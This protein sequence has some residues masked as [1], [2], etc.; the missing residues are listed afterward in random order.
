[1][2]LQGKIAIVTGAAQ[3]IGKAIAKKLAEE[4]AKVYILDYN[5]DVAQKTVETFQANG[6]QS[7]AIKCDI[8]DTS[9]TRAIAEDI[10]GN[11]RH[12]DILVNNAGISQNID[13]LDMDEKNWDRVFNINLRGPFFLTQIIFKNMIEHRNGRIVNLASLAGERGGR[14]AAVNYSCSKGG[15]L[16]L[17]KCLALY[18]AEY[19]VTVNALAPGLIKTP[20]SDQLNHNLNDVPLGRFGTPE[21]VADAAFFLSSERSRYITGMTLDINGGQLMR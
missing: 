1:M 2:E 21:E 7:V 15:V 4:G 20:M 14:F 13:L 5:L 10:I 19:G 3:G 12:V 17:T 11:E 8:S 18:G 16:T 6:L 9:A